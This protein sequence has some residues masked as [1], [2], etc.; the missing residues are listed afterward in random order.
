MAQR[1]G[2]QAAL[3]LLAFFISF[4]VPG[5]PVSAEGD[6]TEKIYQRLLK[7][8]VW[9]VVPKSRD[10]TTHRLLLTTGSGSLIDRS[11]RLVLTN[12]HVVRSVVGKDEKVIVAF[13]VFQNGH[14]VAERGHYVNLISRGG[15][16]GQVMAWDEKCDLAVIQLER[17]PEDARPLPL[18]RESPSP[19]QDVHSV[20][21]PGQSGALWVYTAGKVRQVYHHTWHSG[22]GQDRLDLDA[23]IVETQSPINR[24]DS[25]GPLVNNKAE[26][27]AVT[28]GHLL[29]AQQISLFIDVTEVRAFLRRKKLLPSSTAESSPSIAS[30]AEPKPPDDEKKAATKLEWAKDLAMNGKLEKAKTYCEEILDSYP[31]TKA[32]GG[33]RLLLDKLSK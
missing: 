24:G 2:I 25:G 8:T 30:S 17:V 22:S 28:Q 6:N 1:R 10:A 12:Y 4:C 9:V 18:A 7:S 27:V 19:G 26:L 11:R 33:A 3:G 23:K 13:P 20:G 16:H 15:I 14:A 29:D 5:R 21:N 32:A 31:K